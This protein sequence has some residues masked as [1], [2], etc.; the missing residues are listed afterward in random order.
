MTSEPDFPA[1]DRSLSASRIVAWRPS[2]TFVYALVGLF[3]GFMCLTVFRNLEDWPFYTIRSFVTGKTAMYDITEH[4]ADRW[5]MVG[6]PFVFL[7]GGAF[8]GILFSKK[9]RNPTIDVRP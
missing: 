2:R 7:F 5:V 9:Q 6:L 4:P 8:I 3:C 1:S